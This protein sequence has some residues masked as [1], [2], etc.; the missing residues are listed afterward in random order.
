MGVFEVRNGWGALWWAGLVVVLTILLC[1]SLQGLG[2]VGR[3]WVGAFGE[4]MAILLCGS[5]RG[6]HNTERDF[7]RR[8]TL[9]GRLPA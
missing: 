3:E 1:G 5:F 4:V 6:F 8:R 9:S 7:Q 2:W